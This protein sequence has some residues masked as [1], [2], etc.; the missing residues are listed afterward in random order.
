MFY[1]FKKKTLQTWS[2]PFPCKRTGLFLFFME[3]ILIN[4]TTNDRRK[5]KIFQEWIYVIKAFVTLFFVSLSLSLYVIISRNL[6]SEKGCSEKKPCVYIC[7]CTHLIGSTLQFKTLWL[8]ST[9]QHVF[10]IQ[11]FDFLLQFRRT[12]T[13]PNTQH[14]SEMWDEKWI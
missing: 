6:F 11:L 13:T 8:M 14:L 1:H 9:E 3:F 4:A 10:P 2:T 12:K 5:I 7:K